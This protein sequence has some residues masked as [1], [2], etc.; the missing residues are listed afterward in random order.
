MAEKNLELRLPIVDEHE[1]FA[2]KIE[3]ATRLIKS[4]KDDISVEK[5]SEIKSIMQPRRY[6]EF[7]EG[8]R[9]LL[10][11]AWKLK[12]DSFLK[13]CA[14][15]FLEEVLKSG[16]PVDISVIFS[17][18]YRTISQET[19]YIVCT[20]ADKIGQAYIGTIIYEKMTTLLVKGVHYDVVRQCDV[21][22]IDGEEDRIKRIIASYKKFAGGLK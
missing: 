11:Q 7:R 3:E 2:K 12:N 21:P 6:G 22:F 13:V 9:D 4:K 14:M 10:I 5:S 20:Y 8:Y 17:M 19:E 15:S 16:E 18:L 1:E